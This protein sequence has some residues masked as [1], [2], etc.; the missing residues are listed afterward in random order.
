MLF[1]F[2]YLKLERER[3]DF[4]DIFADQ[5]SEEL[6]LHSKHKDQGMG[7]WGGDIEE[8]DLEFQVHFEE[9]SSLGQVWWHMP[10]IPVIRR[11]RQRIPSSHTARA[12]LKRQN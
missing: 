1:C 6:G 4:E 9:S 7:L 5:R 2:C 10:I 3:D 11:L 12:C 8:K